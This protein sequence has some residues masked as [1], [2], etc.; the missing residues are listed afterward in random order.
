MSKG[1]EAKNLGGRPSTYSDEVAATICERI[2]EGESLRSICRDE[3]M[4][5]L[6]T[7]FDWLTSNEGFSQHYAIARETQADTLA[8]EIVGIADDTSGDAQRD[9]LRVDARKWVASKLK[10]RR[11]GDRV[12]AEHS[13]PDGGPIETRDTSPR[14][15]AKILLAKF[16][17]AADE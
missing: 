9:R 2:A 7:V 5:P 10:P 17:E 13:G 16:G 11:Y 14:D 6:R 3:T 4:P 12:H 1:K 8:D 15:L